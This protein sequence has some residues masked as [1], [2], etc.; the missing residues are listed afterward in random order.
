MRKIFYIIICGFMCSLLVSCSF[1]NKYDPGF[2]L[3]SMN[4]KHLKLLN[5]GMTEDEVLA[6][7]GKPQIQDN[8]KKANILFYYTTWDWADA[9]VNKIECTP[10]IFENDHLIG[11]GLAFYRNYKHKDWLFEV[12]KDELYDEE[13]VGK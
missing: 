8:F 7:M 12:D 11:W 2:V 4:Q 9:A 10:L 5:K 6:I 3:R 13:N 1:I